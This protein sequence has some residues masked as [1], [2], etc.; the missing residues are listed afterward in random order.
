MNPDRYTKIILTTICIFLGILV[1]DR[2][3]TPN[4]AQAQA[5]VPA[6]NAFE[7]VE[8]IPGSAAYAFILFDKKTG[9]FCAYD[10][11][12]SGGFPFEKFGTTGRIEKV[13]AAVQN[14]P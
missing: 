9:Q 8:I 2:L 14:V 4:Q 1:L 13:G 6:A 10:V 3:G 7:N 12:N 11:K 5:P